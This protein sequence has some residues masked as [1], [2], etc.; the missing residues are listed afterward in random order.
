MEEM[1]EQ[2]I[3]EVQVPETVN[4]IKVTEETPQEQPEQPKE[5]K[6]DPI[7]KGVQKRIDRAV[8]EKYEAQARAKML[9]ERL[10]QLE[11]RLQPRQDSVQST[12]SP[13]EPKLDDYQS[14]E[15]F[16]AAKAEF[17][18]NKR[19]ENTLR[20]VQQRQ[21]M[22]R[23]QVARQQAVETW[24]SRLV[25]ATAELPDFEDVL[26]SSEVPLSRDMETAIME[27][28]VV[29]HIAYYL[30]THPDE[31]REIS[32]ASAYSAVRSLGRIEEKIKNGALKQAQKSEA[33]PP[34]EPVGQKTKVTKSPNEMTDA[35]FSEW[36]RKYIKNRHN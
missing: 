13:Q 30:A 16:I 34:I 22:E 29:P 5:E 23:A 15:D 8:R 4:E 12:Q 18:A 27:S 14:Y 20:E 35:E 31:A 1:I 32:R 9:E 33:P 7:P 3:E 36:R 2:P 24:N 25:T 10:S 17:V 6:V 19:V 21:A 11:Q 26:G 28:D